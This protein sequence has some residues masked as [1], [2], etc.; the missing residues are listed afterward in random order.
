M[1]TSGLES[2]RD[3]DIIRHPKSQISK[4][5]FIHE[6]YYVKRKMKLKSQLSPEMVKKCLSRMGGG[7]LS[8]TVLRRG[9]GSKIS[10]EFKKDDSRT[11][12]ESPIDTLI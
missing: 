10:M 2:S 5:P 12:Q 3:I 4:N 11:I 8:R 6:E 7:K 1:A 9:K